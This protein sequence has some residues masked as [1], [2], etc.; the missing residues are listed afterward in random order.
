MGG[1]GLFGYKLE[2]IQN[3]EEIQGENLEAGT[4]ADIIEGRRFTLQCLLSSTGLYNTGNIHARISPS[5]AI[6]NKQNAPQAYPEATL[7]YE[8]S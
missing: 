7:M 6:S 2:L 5:I 4:K 3:K 8:S 1:K